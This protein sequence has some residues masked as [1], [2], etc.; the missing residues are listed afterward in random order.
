MFSIKEYIKKNVMKKVERLN[1]F[2]MA[3]EELCVFV[4]NAE[5]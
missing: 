5:E 2:F 4:Q 3:L 1:E